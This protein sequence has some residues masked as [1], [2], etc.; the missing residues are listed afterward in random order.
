MTATGLHSPV[1]VSAQLAPEPARRGRLR[2]RERPP[3][4]T[5]Q[6]L[7]ATR[8]AYLM[9]APMAVLLGVFVF[10]PLIYSIYLSC[11]RVSFYQGNKWV[12]TA[13]Y[14]YV[15]TDPRFWHA[16]RIGALYA[17]LTVPTGLVVS[18]A[19][20]LFIKTLKGKL[21]A[22]MKTVVYLPAV[23]SSVIAAVVFT[24]VYQDGGVLNAFVGL[25]HINPIAW[26]NEPKTVLPAV[27]VPGVWI[28]LGISTLILL[29][30]LLDIPASYYESAA[31]DGAGLWKQTRYITIPM[32]RNVFLYLFVTGFTV[33]IQEFQLPLIMT[34]GGPV[35]AT[36]TPNLYIFNSFRD[37]T[38]YATSFSLAAALLLFVVLGAISL[39]IFKLIRS[40]KAVDG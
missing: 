8:T 27:A 7:R 18:L 3:A 38:P 37:N 11:Y 19:L 36:N 12:G 13:F 28:G 23:L 29:S 4:L 26:L 15:L 17:L 25:F 31:L 5:A 30:A 22:L 10:W 32:L 21:A 40:E 20:A 6:H 24:L 33:A 35:D 1:E 14:R 2:R 16:I 9:L 39:V 34:G